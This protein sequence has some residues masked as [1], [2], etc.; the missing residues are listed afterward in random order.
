MALALKH[1]DR[2]WTFGAILETCR[3]AHRWEM[4]GG[5]VFVVFGTMMFCVGMFTAIYGDVHHGTSNAAQPQ[6]PN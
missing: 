5:L 3:G 2:P 4:I 6:C 1:D